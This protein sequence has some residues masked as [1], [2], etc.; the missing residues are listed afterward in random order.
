MTWQLEILPIK[1]PCVLAELG[2]TVKETIR[3]WLREVIC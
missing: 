1:Q 3:R 2:R